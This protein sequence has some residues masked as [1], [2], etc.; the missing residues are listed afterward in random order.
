MAFPLLL[1][2]SWRRRRWELVGCS[3][4]ADNDPH[5]DACNCKKKSGEGDPTNEALLPP[6]PHQPFADHFAVS[7]GWNSN[8]TLAVHDLTDDARPA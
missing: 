7:M 1:L 2:A 4:W 8:T 3:L 6:Y 5:H